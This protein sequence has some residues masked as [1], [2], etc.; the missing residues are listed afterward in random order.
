MT[1][2]AFTTPPDVDIEVS[3]IGHPPT[4]PR[5]LLRPGESDRLPVLGRRAWT[6]SISAV[7]AVFTD[8][9]ASMTK[10]SCQAVAHL[11]LTPDAGS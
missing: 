3:L 2:T 11:G 4:A 7:S 9:P 1:E 5:L 6:S 8:T 10:H